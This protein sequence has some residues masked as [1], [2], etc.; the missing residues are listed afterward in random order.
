MVGTGFAI[1]RKYY[2]QIGMSNS[3]MGSP[4]KIDPTTICRLSDRFSMDLRLFEIHLYYETEGN[5]NF[6]RLF[7]Q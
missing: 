1:D 2:N 3:L 4:R 6:M 7:T 5:H